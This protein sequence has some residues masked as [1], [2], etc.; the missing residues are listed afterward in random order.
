MGIELHRV[1]LDL[2]FVILVCLVSHGGFLELNIQQ[3][4]HSLPLNTTE[5]RHQVQFD[6]KLQNEMSHSHLKRKYTTQ[7]VGTEK[8]HS[9]LYRLD[10]HHKA[11]SALLGYSLQSCFI[12]SIE[13]SFDES[14]LSNNSK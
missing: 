1:N 8:I 2:P 6:L 12:P 4:H 5:N 10:R 13:K 14:E 3:T 7:N 11:E 9:L